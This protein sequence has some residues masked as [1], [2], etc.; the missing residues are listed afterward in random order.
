MRVAESINFA[1][2][3]FLSILAWVRPLPAER[4]LRVTALGTLG[5]GLTV[6]AQLAHGIL[7]PGAAAVVRDWLPAVLI[8]LA[9]R[10]AGLC[11]ADTNTRL[12]AKLSGFDVL[13]L[14]R[15]KPYG[16]NFTRRLLSACFEF[17]YLFCYPMIPLGM[18]ALY[19]LGR[20]VHADRFWAVVLPAAYICYGF[21]PFVQVLPPWMSEQ[22]G[23]ASVPENP[24]RRFNMWIVDHLSIRVDTFPSAHVAASTATA[25]AL[26]SLAPPVGMAFAVLALSIAIASVVERYH[27]A[28]DALLGAAVALGVFFFEAGFLHR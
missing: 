14:R 27:Y 18:G 22:I 7:E 13:L 20:Q 26:L 19:L 16:N 25:F 21:L 4:R 1:F 2:F 15:L 10:Q 28:A 23:H 5:M 8:I 11:S 17:A 6:A 12:Q 3:A 24:F 9:Y